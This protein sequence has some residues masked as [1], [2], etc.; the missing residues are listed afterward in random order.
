MVD[1]YGRLAH[2]KE[3]GKRVLF[4][5]IVVEIVKWSNCN[6]NTNTHTHTGMHVL[7]RTMK[8]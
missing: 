6:A 4:A 1:G 2:R 7:G 5:K 8:L 3:A